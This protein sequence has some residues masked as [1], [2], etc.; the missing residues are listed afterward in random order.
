VPPLDARPTVDRRN[1]SSCT[2]D[3][4]NTPFM[5]PG[6]T[7]DGMPA[8]E[9]TGTIDMQ[10]E[11][12]MHR[13]ILRIADGTFVSAAAVA[14]PAWGDIEDDVVGLSDLRVSCPG[15]WLGAASS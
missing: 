11:Q 2:S 6:P 8:F 12:T 5:V 3:G 15:C 13:E 1:G 10:L 14:I 7:N 4:R 9:L